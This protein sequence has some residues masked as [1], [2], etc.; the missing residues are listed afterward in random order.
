VFVKGRQ[1]TV[2]FS[3]INFSI[4]EFYFALYFELPGSDPE[5]G[6]PDG[7]LL[8][9]HSPS[10]QMPQTVPRLILFISLP[11]QYR[12]IRRC[13]SEVLTAS[14]SVLQKEN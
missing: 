14:L 3:S 10:K 13:W 5:T 1:Y 11:I 9:F 4:S 2:Y 6:C 7:V 8:V 12:I